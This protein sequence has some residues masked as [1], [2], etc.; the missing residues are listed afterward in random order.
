[1]TV[2][3]TTNE[4]REIKDLFP[5]RIEQPMGFDFLLYSKR[6]PFPI[7]RKAIP[8]DLLASV[9]DGR[10]QRELIAMREFGSHYLILLHGKFK[11]KD[12]ALIMPQ[13][14]MKPWSK[15]GIRN[16]MRSLQL[17]E[18]AIIDQAETDEELV[19]VVN[20]WQKYL[21]SDEHRSIRNRPTIKYEFNTPTR[22]EKVRYFYEGLPEIKYE[23]AKTLQVLY[24]NPIDLYKASVK[25]IMEIKG[26]GKTLSEGIYNFLRGV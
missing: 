26:F 15:K 8:G 7:E 20:E 5:D 22:T 6:F 19:C 11:Y 13:K 23:R 4:P 17:M 3:I 18:G 16:L 12:D 2:I 9:Q 1:L 10:L 24:P 14:S 25:D 21:D